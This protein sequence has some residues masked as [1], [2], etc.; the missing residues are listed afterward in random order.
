MTSLFQK[1][2]FTLLLTHNAIVVIVSSIHLTKTTVTL[3]TSHTFGSQ[4]IELI[5]RKTNI[6]LIFQ[7][8]QHE[9]IR[10]I[11]FPM[12]IV[13]V[14]L[15]MFDFVS[16]QI[17]LNHRILR[18]VRFAFFNVVRLHASILLTSQL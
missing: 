9:S 3:L 4:L 5:L 17:L 13:Q 18:V 12:R 11:L 14:H 16:N 6:I 1:V 7:V 10:R 15:R 8:M 2:V